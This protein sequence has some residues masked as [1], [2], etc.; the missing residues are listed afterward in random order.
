MIALALHNYAEMHPVSRDGSAAVP[1]FPA[2]AIPNLALPV[3]RRLSWIVEILPHLDQESLARSIDR[4]GSWNSPAAQ[5]QM[6]TLRCP[7]LSRESIAADGSTPYI[8]IAGLGHDAPFLAANPKSGVFGYDRR[9]AFA[10]ITDGMANT[11]MILESSRENGPWARGGP[12]TVRG[13]STNDQ[14]YLGAGCQFGGTHFSENTLFSRAKPI[15]CSAALADGSVRFLVNSIAP[16]VLEAVT[17][18]AGGEA[19]M[20]EW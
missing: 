20:P 7:D 10:D 6:R 18:A 19:A 15:D 5:M 8:G 13:L 17:T 3:D 4:A 12:S 2:G 16:D 11:L 14:P 1:A 9:T